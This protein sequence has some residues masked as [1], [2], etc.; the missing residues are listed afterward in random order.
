MTL[1][2]SDL[3]KI[4]SKHPK[5][6][7]F[8]LTNETHRKV[9]TYVKSLD[10]KGLRIL[11]E[12]DAGLFSE[13]ANYIS[14]L[15]AKY[16]VDKEDI[17]DV[18]D[19]LD[20]EDTVDVKE[21]SDEEELSDWEKKAIEDYERYTN[22]KY[23]NNRDDEEMGNTVKEGEAIKDTAV[24]R[25]KALKRLLKKNSGLDNETLVNIKKFIDNVKK[26]DYAES[27][28]IWVDKIKSNIGNEL[29]K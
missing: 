6:E 18:K 17:D 2:E 10:D 28:K 19:K 8:D 11:R 7:N 24:K 22:N 20:S 15:E 4:K 29:R 13:L 27:N 9:W 23:Y 5:G 16:E 12:S 26:G 1:T 3:N 25:A 14:I 21:D